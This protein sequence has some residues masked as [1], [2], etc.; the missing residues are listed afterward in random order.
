LIQCAD[1]FIYVVSALGVTGQRDTVNDQLP[2]LV[3]RIRAKTDV[4][5]A[6][7][8]GVSTREHF[9]IV[10]READGVVIGSQIVKIANSV[11]KG[12]RAAALE[13]YCAL[14]SGR[15]EVVEKAA[16]G[17]AALSGL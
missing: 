13:K 8:F 14:V 3:S 12:E 9:Q 6:V 2:A 1:S 4:P 10:G 11:P 5:L 15:D 7:G 16:N 17:V